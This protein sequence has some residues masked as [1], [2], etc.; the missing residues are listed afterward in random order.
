MFSLSGISYLRMA[1]L[2]NS[3]A[4]DSK[5]MDSKKQWYSCRGWT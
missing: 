2:A 1:P 3:L 4:K 5:S